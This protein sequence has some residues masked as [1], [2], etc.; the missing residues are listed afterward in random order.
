MSTPRAKRPEIARSVEP[1]GYS[2][3]TS[4]Y[5][6]SHRQGQGWPQTLV[7]YR[8]P[9]TMAF[10]NGTH[11]SNPSDRLGRKVELR[12]AQLETKNAE[13]ALKS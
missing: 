13:L 12:P 6:S 3:S 2:Q 8:H 9:I 1:T 5:A 4:I 10:S 11:I 7:S